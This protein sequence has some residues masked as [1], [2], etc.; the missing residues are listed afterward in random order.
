MPLEQTACRSRFFVKAVPARK[1]IR[2]LLTGG[3]SATID[4]T[5]LTDVFHKRYPHVWHFYQGVPREICVFL[6]QGAQIIFQDLKPHLRDTEELC[7]TAY[8]KLVRELGHGLYN[9]RSAEDTCVGALCESYDLW[10]DAHGSSEQFAQYRFSLLELLMS[11]ME[12]EFAKPITDSGFSLF[13]KS[14]AASG[15]QSDPRKD[16]FR[17]AVQELNHR[18]RESRIPFHYHNGIFQSGTDG[19]TESQVHE[20]FWTLLQ[21]PKW[22][23]VDIDIKEAIDRRDLGRKM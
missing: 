3:R 12:A 7:H 16:A 2:P 13:K 17:K 23:N 8:S 6:R 5:M 15:S 22:K 1:L 18:L 10:N 20:P 4:V 19:V 21:D 9:G 14:Q 11:E